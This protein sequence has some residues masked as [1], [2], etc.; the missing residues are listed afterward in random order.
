MSI[1]PQKISLGKGL[2]VDDGVKLGYPTGRKIKDTFLSI[3]GE[4]VLRSGTVIY[5]GSKIGKEFQ[6][7]HN[8]VIREENTIGDHVWIW[9]NTVVD[10]GC[11]IGNN[12]RIH[13]NVYIAQ[14]TVI[15]DDV[16][17]APCVAVANDM[18]PVGTVEDLHG[19]VIK[20]GARI[21]INVTLLPGVVIGEGAM[22]GAG[23]VVTKNVPPGV[24][25]VGNPARV[26]RQV[27]EIRRTPRVAAAKG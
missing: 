8:V 23:S 24:I 26:I 27:S 11:T 19:P 15:E 5:A 3:G 14:F 2:R 22:I 4:G 1:D 10:Y 17:M 25:A 7:G 12:V 18:Y 9:G 6:T 13:S 21:G 16:F 20:K